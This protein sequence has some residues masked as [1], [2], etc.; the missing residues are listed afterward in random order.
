M[1]VS[2][3]LDIAVKN[4]MI[5]AFFFFLNLMIFFLEFGKHAIKLLS[6]YGIVSFERI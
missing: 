3:H 1:Q 4:M 2:E 6:V 5:F